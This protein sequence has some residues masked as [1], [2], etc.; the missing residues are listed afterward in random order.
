[1]N[2][3]VLVDEIKHL[4]NPL[5]VPQPGSSVR[6]EITQHN[7]EFELARHNNA[8]VHEEGV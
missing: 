3:A 7:I 5:A 2:Q 1:M 8:R 6:C 4:F